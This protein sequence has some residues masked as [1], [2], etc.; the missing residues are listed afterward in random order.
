[1]TKGFLELLKVSPMTQGELSRAVGLDQTA[2]SRWL[3]GRTEPT[4]EQVKAV[5][6]AIERRLQTIEH[7]LAFVWYQTVAREEDE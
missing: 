2:V 7:S 5:V 4:T 1:M 3:H 6:R